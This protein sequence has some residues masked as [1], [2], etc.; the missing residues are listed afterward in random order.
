MFPPFNFRFNNPN[1]EDSKKRFFQNLFPVQ[2]KQDPYSSLGQSTEAQQE[3][4]G[5][6]DVYRELMNRQ[7]GPAMENY[8]KFVESETPTRENTKVGKLTRLGAILS[9]AASG[10]TNPAS[11]AAVAQNIMDRPFNQR[12]QE[13]NYKGDQLR[14]AASLEEASNRSRTTAVKAVGD[15]QNQAADNK[16]QDQ[17]AKSLIEQRALTAKE[18]QQRIEANG[19]TFHLNKADGIGYLVKRDGSMTPVGKFDQST[20][21][22]LDEDLSKMRTQSDLTGTRQVKLASMNNAFSKSQQEDRQL[23][24]TEMERQRQTGRKEL[25]AERA[26][27]AAEN[28]IKRAG[29]TNSANTINQLRQIKLNINKVESMV[30]AD[31]DK[32]EDFWDGEN[33]MD[34]PSTDDPNYEAFTELYN[35][36]YAGTSVLS[37]KPTKSGNTIVR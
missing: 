22:K 11:G 31:P 28:A 19:A 12:M 35:A 4:P 27:L 29:L 37:S 6:M 3:Q 5:F 36:L 25:T 30:A 26:K 8:R 7:N 15:L 34:T 14:E 32:Y 17:L 13:H 23:H 2:E 9:G 21:E 33:L 10:F 1:P 20:G 16:R 24:D 18:T